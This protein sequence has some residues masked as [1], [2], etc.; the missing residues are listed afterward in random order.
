MVNLEQIPKPVQRPQ[1]STFSEQEVHED[2]L[3]ALR[4]IIRATDLHSKRVSRES[5]LTIPQIVVLKSVR[6]LGEVTTSAISRQVSLSQATVTLILDRLEER[7]LVERYRSTRDRRIVHSRLTQEGRL[8]LRKAPALL[9]ER[10]LREFADL[11]DRRQREI[12][13]ALQK[14]ADMMGASG[15]DAAPLLEVGSVRK[16]TGTQS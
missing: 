12:V 9:H 5:G 14:V 6:D 10:F 16:G 3:V 2:L 7:G 8:A 11:S 15:L 13:K 4:R 1:R